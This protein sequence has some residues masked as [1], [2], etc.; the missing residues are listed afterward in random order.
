M[1]DY[2]IEDGIYSY[3][4]S[5]STITDIVGTRIYP[6]L[7]PQD[8]TLP[9]VVFFNI[10]SEPVAMQDQKPIAMI[11]HIQV[12]CFA[13]TIRAA[14]ILDKKIKEA[15]LLDSYQGVMFG[16]S[17][18]RRVELIEGGVDDF[19]DIPNNFRVTSDYQIWHIVV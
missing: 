6:G 18:I 15:L 12:D 11:T 9:V 5:Q 10:G 17:P 1:T 3:L 4:T 7:L 2:F 8:P 14:K 16:S 13:L 19:D